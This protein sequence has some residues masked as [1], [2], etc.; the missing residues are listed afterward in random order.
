MRSGERFRCEEKDIREIG[1]ARNQRKTSSKH[2]ILNKLI[3]KLKRELF[4]HE[5]SCSSYGRRA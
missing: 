5:L 1:E 3:D 4:S 2:E